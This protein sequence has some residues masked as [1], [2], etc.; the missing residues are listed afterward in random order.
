MV[1]RWSDNKS[2]K[3]R[4]IEWAVKDVAG[5]VDSYKGKPLDAIVEGIH[6]S[7]A[8]IRA[9]VELGGVYYYLTVMLAGIRGPSDES[10]I[11]PRAIYFLE[12]GLLHASG[13]QLQ[14]DSAGSN[15]QLFGRVKHPDFDIVKLVLINGLA[16][17]QDWSLLSMEPEYVEELRAAESTAKQERK[18]IWKNYKETVKADR[19]QST[20]KVVEVIAADMLVIKDS[21]NNLKKIFISSI[22]PPRKETQVAYA[23]G[24][25]TMAQKMFQQPLLFEAREFLRKALI[26]KNVQVQTDFIQPK[27]DLYP[28]KVCC[29]VTIGGKNIAEQLV[30]KGLASVIRYRQDND[31]RSP[32]YLELQKAENTAQKSGVGLYAKKDPEPMK[33]VDLQGEPIKSKQYFSSLQRSN[34]LEGIVEFVSSGSR[35]RV[36]CAKHACI[37]PFL[38]NG[39]QCP[40]ASRL[41]QNGQSRIGGDP[42]GD[43]ALMFTKDQCLQHEINME[44]ESQDKN[45]AMI[46]KATIAGKNLAVELVKV[47]LATVHHY[48]AEKLHYYKDLC[49]AEELAKKERLRLWKN[50]VEEVK[51]ETEE[52]IEEA[53]EDQ[54]SERTV[55]FKT[56]H[57]SEITSE[58]TKFYVQYTNDREKF[59]E[60]HDKLQEELKNTSIAGPFKRGER[61]AAKFSDGNWYRVKIEKLS[62]KKA[63]LLYVDYGNRGECPPNQLQR[64]PAFCATTPDVAHLVNLAFVK[65]P[66][67]EEEVLAARK[68]FA[69]N[70]KGE[71]KMNVEY[72]IQGE[73]RIEKETAF[74][75]LR[76][77]WILPICT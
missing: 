68:V 13:I 49:N 45:G 48:S 24:K 61:A 76:F 10:G 64:L 20:A 8:G 34:P 73:V 72:S 59:L 15:G 7:A 74:T 1:F 39:I 38:L 70:V 16:Q 67:D 60:M 71:V 43:D 29:T 37:F 5:F 14:L 11:R 56:V 22:R 69:K 23:P 21:S 65:M 52:L 63:D 9:Y 28:E 51:E 25:L 18:G 58:V 53:R 12:C 77:K 42:F 36:Y 33:V 26:G 44:V 46:G 55:D 40:R 50:Y 31:Q 17:T 75:V 62:P 19:S 32:Y 35:L 6:P 2:T 54:K 47:G 41:D 27:S 57:V 66:K 30:A 4:E 3:V